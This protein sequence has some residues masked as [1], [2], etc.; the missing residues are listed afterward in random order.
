M[1]AALRGVPRHATEVPMGR[2]GKN[3]VRVTT[4]LNRALSASL[5]R[6]ARQHDVAVSWLVRRAVERLI[7]HPDLFSSDDSSMG[8]RQ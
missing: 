2:D 4:T 3:S 1:S 6:L 5:E 8:K 7:E